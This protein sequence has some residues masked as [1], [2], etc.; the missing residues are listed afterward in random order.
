MVFIYLDTFMGI[1]E[2]NSYKNKQD[3]GARKGRGWE[4]SLQHLALRILR[5]VFSATS[6]A[7]KTGVSIHSA[8]GYVSEAFC[9][10]VSPQ[11]IYLTVEMRV[12]FNTLP[13]DTMQDL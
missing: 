9:E 2:K 12:L 3:G 13:N 8:R 7:R 10:A 11:P 4:V 5:G 6:S 1:S